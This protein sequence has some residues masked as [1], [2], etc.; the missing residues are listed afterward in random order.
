MWQQQNIF[1]EG[2]Y[3]GSVEDENVN[4]LWK[5]ET[6]YNCLGL[7]ENEIFA[8]Y[9]MRRLLS[10]HLWETYIDLGSA[11]SSM[12]LEVLML[13]HIPIFSSQYMYYSVLTLSYDTL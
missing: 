13:N 12:I 2:T 7:A 3:L 8:W 11:V 6:V 4:A 1:E 5:T 10:F 9:V